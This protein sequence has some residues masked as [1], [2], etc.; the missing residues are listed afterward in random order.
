LSGAG[1]GGGMRDWRATFAPD[2]ATC[3]RAYLVDLAA[4]ALL[5]FGAG[6]MAGRVWRFPFDDEIYTLSTIAHYPALQL[7]FVFP[8]RADV[9]PPLSYLLFEG[10]Q[11]L[12]LSDAGM[13]LVS[14]VMTALALFQ[15]LALSMIA[16][17]GPVA[18]VSRL[19]AVLLFGLC[20]LAVSQGDALRWYPL[21]ALLIALFVTLYLAGGND[22]ARLWSAVA[23]GLAGSVNVLAGTVALALAIYRYGL[24]RRWRASFDLPYWGITALCGAFGIYTVLSLL[25][26]RHAIVATQ[27]GNGILRSALT[28]GLGFFG[29]AALGVSQ[30][31]IVVPAAAIAGVAA[32]AAIDRK[33]PANPAHLLL[34]MLAGA[35]LTILPGFDK[36]RSFLYLAPAVA[37]LVALWLDGQLR[38]GR[39]GRVLVLAALLLAASAGTIANTAHS[40][41]PFKRV[42]VIPYGSIVDFIDGNG[43]GRVLV[44]STDPVVPWLLNERHDAGRCAAYFLQALRC[45]GAGQHYD[46]IFVVRGHSDKS[47]KPA[48]MR[49]FN[50]EVGAATAGRSKVATLRAGRDVDAALKSRLAGVTLDKT[51]LTVDLYR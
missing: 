50:D 27:L 28:D 31:W 29:G 23:L 44:L 51:L 15:L 21:F 36:P 12:G 33:D 22:A 39:V 16:R 34:L 3:A 8:G 40:T 10:L 49:H 4:A 32:L 14:L 42:A 18:P 38:A 46:S 19:I 45:L 25:T 13:R 20:P 7:V 1:E 41:H 24:Q 37:M 30:A 43:T 26:A 48:L 35:A 2:Y 17:R 47:A 11:H 9:H 5:F 6:A